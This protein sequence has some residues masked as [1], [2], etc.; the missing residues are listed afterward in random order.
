MLVYR[1]YS[2]IKTYFK[3]GKKT[4]MLE[5]QQEINHQQNYAR[6]L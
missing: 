4:T 2:S 5:N 6:R 3:R 1:G